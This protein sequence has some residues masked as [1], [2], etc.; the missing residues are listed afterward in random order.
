MIDIL[1]LTIPALLVL[2]TAY[3]LLDKML[4]NDEK[5]R[6][7]ELK[8]RNIQV[9]TP[10]RLRAYE[11]LTL[12]LDRTKPT[13]I[14]LEVLKPV[15]TC[16]E[17]Q[18]QLLT[19]IREEF[20]HNASQQIYVSNELWSA[21]R[22]TQESLIQLVNLCAAQCAADAIGTEL[23]EKIIQ[24]YAQSDNSPGEVATVMLKK[25]VRDLF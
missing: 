14:V 8:Q 2:A 3:I 22:A 17:L 23:A 1:Q 21:I 9:T 16:F 7:F 10:L 19:T 11:R 5:R 18:S 25:E 6:N 4:K 20:G 15:M 12:V 24:L 13:S